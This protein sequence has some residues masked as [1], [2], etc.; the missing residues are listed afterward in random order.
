MS[1]IREQQIGL[2]DVIVYVMAMV[3]VVGAVAWSWNLILVLALIVAT[4]PYATWREIRNLEQRN[5][6]ARQ[7]I[8]EEESVSHAQIS[9]RPA[10]TEKKLNGNSRVYPPGIPTAGAIRPKGTPHEAVECG[11]S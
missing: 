2:F 10:T 7:T 6:P 1:T 4:V 3:A 5:D 11:K 8:A 9:E